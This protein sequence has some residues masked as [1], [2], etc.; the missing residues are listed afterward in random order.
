MRKEERQIKEE[1]ETEKEKGVGG[2]G[3][4]KERGTE[5]RSKTKGTR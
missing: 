5:E 1:R 3:R 4:G 2:G